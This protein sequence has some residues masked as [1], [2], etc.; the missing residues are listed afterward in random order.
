MFLNTLCSQQAAFPAIISLAVPNFERTLS[1]LSFLPGCKWVRISPCLTW[2]RK[3]SPAQYLNT[4]TQLQGVFPQPVKN[5][6][7][8]NPKEKIQGTA[9]I[10]YWNETAGEQFWLCWCGRL[11]ELLQ[12][13]LVLLAVWGDI[14]SQWQGCCPGEWTPWILELPK[15]SS[16]IAL[17][18]SI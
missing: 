5:L 18:S 14:S 17:T 7:S 9:G 3:S 13:A 8:H 4:N 2:G 6:S 1:I 16:H 12:S 11:G 10:P 15:D